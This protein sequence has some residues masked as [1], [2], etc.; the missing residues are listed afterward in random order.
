M[1]HVSRIC[2]LTIIKVM[3]NRKGVPSDLIA[4]GSRSSLSLTTTGL[5]NCWCRCLLM[6]ITTTAVE[7]VGHSA[8]G[9][10]ISSSVCDP[11]KSV[12]GILHHSPQ[13]GF[14]R[15][16][17]NQHCAIANGNITSRHQQTSHVFASGE[18]T[19]GMLKNI[20]L[21]IFSPS[22]FRQQ[23]KNEAGCPS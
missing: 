16:G 18:N 17:V 11:G 8:S 2:S 13:E 6:R 4:C 22:N 12:G 14:I 5:R 23:G 7:E 20:T 21:L 10:G 3:N 1:M 9:S 19:N 15:L